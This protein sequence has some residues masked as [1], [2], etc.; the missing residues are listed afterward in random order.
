MNNS[1]IIAKRATLKFANTIVIYI[2]LFLLIA[3]LTF[4]FSLISII[5]EN[6]KTVLLIIFIGVGA[7]LEIVLIILFVYS[8][9]KIKFNNSLTKNAITFNNNVFTIYTPYETIKINKSK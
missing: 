4:E 7:L 5:N 9:R 8:I 6:L 2:S 3:F 1:K